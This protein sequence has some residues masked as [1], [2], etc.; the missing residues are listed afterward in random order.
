M[1]V[2]ECLRVVMDD[3]KVPCYYLAWQCMASLC[4]KLVCCRLAA[5][6]LLSSVSRERFSTHYGRFYLVLGCCFFLKRLLLF[7][8][9]LLIWHI[10]VDKSPGCITR[11]KSVAFTE[12]SSY[13]ILISLNITRSKNKVIHIHGWTTCRSTTCIY[14]IDGVN[15]YF[16]LSF[17]FDTHCFLGETCNI[18]KGYY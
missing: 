7:V 6:H 12:R 11:E 1:C 4:L 14:K 13:N 9:Y 5:D 17:S 3:C 10:K 16:M 18:F 8:L 15:I 2:F